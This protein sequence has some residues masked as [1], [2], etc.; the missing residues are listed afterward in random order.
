MMRVEVSNVPRFDRY[1][2]SQLVV[3]FG[4]FSLVLVLV[5]WINRAVVLFDRLIADGQS[6]SVFFE[7]TALS[8]PG[9]IRL[10]LPLSAFAAT[11]Y[12]TNRMT[13]ESELVVVQATGY[14]PY[15]LARPVLYF[16]IIV[17]ALMTLLMHVLVPLAS[18]RLD[19]RQT[20]IAKNITARFLTPGVFLE[21][22]DGLTFYI[23][24]V[25]PAGELQNVFLTD[26]R[27]PAQQVTYTA[28]KAYL[29]RS[30]ASTQLVMVD[31]LAQILQSDSQVLS[32]TSFK[33]FAY[34]IGSFITASTREGRRA[35]QVPT[36]ELLQANDVLITETGQTKGQLIARAHDR[37]SQSI[38]GSVAAL[39]GFA[40][41]IVGG[42]SRFGV[43]RQVLLAIFLIIVIK[44]VETVGLTAARND[45]SLW[46]AA[47]TASIVGMLIIAGLL[48]KAARPALFKRRIAT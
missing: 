41:L 40:A 10:A 11:V 42:F 15:R 46:F 29:V 31:G 3:M 47:Y 36:L 26:L 16:G 32:T 22:T 35:D 2:L 5:Y 27:D 44:A 12:V 8:L 45:P 20:E 38:L 17:F 30:G 7:F 13:A 4:F 9:V 28:S 39:L 21:P 48:F 6:A 37:L 18:V 23:G 34:D 1:M 43:W 33:D 25:T 24:D 19:A 14:S